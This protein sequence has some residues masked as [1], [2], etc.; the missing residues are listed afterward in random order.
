VVYLFDLLIRG[1]VSTHVEFG[2]QIATGA[3]SYAAAVW[4][5]APGTL[6]E[7]RAALRR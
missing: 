1:E 2:L 6:N 4:V 5:M 3:V 7:V